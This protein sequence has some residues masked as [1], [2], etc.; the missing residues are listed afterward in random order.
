MPQQQIQPNTSLIDGKNILNANADDA[1][2]RIAENEAGVQN[3]LSRT[4]H[5][6]QQ[7]ASTI[8]DFDTEVNALLSAV[9]GAGNGFDADTIDGVQLAQLI[10]LAQK[11]AA[12]GVCEL[13]GNALIPTSR[14]PALAISQPYTVSS[15]AAMLALTA[16][17]GD[18]AVR[19]DV[20]Q[21][22]ILA[23]NDPTVVANWIQL[24]VPTDAVLSINGQTG[25]VN[26]TASDVGALPADYAPTVADIEAT[27]ARDGTTALFGD[28]AWKVPPA[29]GG[30]G[31][32]AVDT[33]AAL[34]SI[35]TSN[36]TN[37]PSGTTRKVLGYYFRGD[38][39]G[40]RTYWLDRSSAETDNGGTIVA[41]TTGVG[42]WKKV[43][44]WKFLKPEWF[45]GRGDDT[46]DDA[47]AFRTCA[48]LLDSLGG[49]TM[50]VQWGQYRFAS[51]VNG[52]GVEFLQSPE[53]ISVIGEAGFRISLH[54]DV[55]EYGIV[56][57]A[58]VP[59]DILRFGSN[60]ISGSV[61]K[62]GGPYVTNIQFKDRTGATA[63]FRGLQATG[64]RLNAC[65]GWKIERCGFAGLAWGTLN[66]SNEQYWGDPN[67]PFGAGTNTT[68]TD[69]SWATFRD[70]SIY[71]CTVGYHVP[72][73]GGTTVENNEIKLQRNG[74]I[75]V[76]IAGGSQ[77]R[78][79][80]NKT[81]GL[82][83]L[84][85]A[86]FLRF[87]GQNSVIYGNI[88]EDCSPLIEFYNYTPAQ[89]SGGSPG[90]NN[91]AWGNVLTS[92]TMTGATL[93]YFGSGTSGNVVDAPSSR[94]E[95][96]MAGGPGLAGNTVENGG[97][98]PP[99]P[100]ET[101]T[102]VAPIS[103]QYTWAVPN[104][105]TEYK[106]GTA[107]FLSRL[108]KRL[109]GRTQVRLVAGINTAG[110]AGTQFALRYS[111]D[112]GATWNPIDDA[113][114]GRVAVDA[115]GT[116]AGAFVNISAAAKNDVM[117]ALFGVGGNGGTNVGYMG[118]YVEL[119]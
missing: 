73:S 12:N 102:F 97:S 103:S 31:L 9:Q 30:T 85:N 41:P 46:G 16:Q 40:E 72:H 44:N 62:F 61:S 76:W 55:G 84:T 29:G 114:G 38:M 88:G 42:R 75:G 106:S 119:V 111:T 13:D 27:G 92:P 66:V 52:A 68:R 110:L 107:P 80:N 63:P 15:E 74:Q 4:N 109:D 11:G 101:L 8:S 87:A 70:N 116:N 95:G 113:D 10:Q 86:V 96:T 78:I 93:Y 48:G 49:G 50:Q 35:D 34:K 108:R 43:G 2:L 64:I 115:V 19:S 47:P 100:S 25:V 28:G 24:P 94:A 104:P 79:L 26:L 91:R 56:L 39:A 60:D 81:D 90:K 59:M 20:N 98:G 99:S 22:F 7:S 118:I 57:K 14:M 89:P 32:T 112:N 83:G 67:G 58:T 105:L 53:K 3:A 23:A 65:N 5:T 69:A 6:G 1:E 21:T 77:M 37:F 17:T 82:N 117:L 45:G 36:A 18:V 71:D 51:M 54:G 33:I